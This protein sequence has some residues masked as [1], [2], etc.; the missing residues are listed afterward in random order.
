MNATDKKIIFLKIQMG[1]FNQYFNRLLLI[2][3]KFDNQK[4]RNLNMSNVLHKFNQL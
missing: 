3:D 2:F 4:E 1:V